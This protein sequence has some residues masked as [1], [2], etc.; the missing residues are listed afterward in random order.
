MSQRQRRSAIQ[1]AAGPVTS[2]WGGNRAQ[3]AGSEGSLLLR[4]GLMN[5]GVWFFQVLYLGEK[6]QVAGESEKRMPGSPERP[7]VEASFGG[8]ENLASG[9]WILWMM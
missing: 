5:E 3:M 8:R 4:Q 6:Y 7:R 1:K 9:P 2:V